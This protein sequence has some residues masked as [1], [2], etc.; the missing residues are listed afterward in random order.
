LS[1]LHNYCTEEKTP[2][3]YIGLCAEAYYTEDADKSTGVAG[4]DVQ[5]AIIDEI[6]SSLAEGLPA[7]DCALTVNGIIDIHSLTEAHPE[8]FE[9]DGIHPNADGAKAIAELVADAIR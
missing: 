2:K 1:F 5:P 6:A 7:C 8:W 4:F 3:V 9:E